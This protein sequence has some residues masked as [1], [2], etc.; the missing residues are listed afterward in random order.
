LAR[1]NELAWDSD[2]RMRRIDLP[3][4]SAN[5]TSYRT[6]GLRHQLRGVEGDRGWCGTGVRRGPRKAGDELLVPRRIEGVVRDLYS[7]R[8]ESPRRTTFSSS[9]KARAGRVSSW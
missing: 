8:L 4:A 3:D 1:E 7:S 5:T 6:D 2:N 9:E